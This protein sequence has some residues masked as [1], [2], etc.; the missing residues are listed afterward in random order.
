MVLAAAGALIV[1]ATD[2]WTIPVGEDG[3]EEVFIGKA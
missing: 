3:Y 2:I 1:L